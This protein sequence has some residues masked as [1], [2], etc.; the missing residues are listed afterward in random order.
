MTRFADELPVPVT[1]VERLVLRAILLDVAWRRGEAVH[2]SVHAHV[3]GYRPTECAF[4]PTSTL[5]RFWKSATEGPAMAFRGWI[6][7]FFSEFDRTHRA[8]A[9]TRAAKTIRRDYHQRWS[10]STLARRLHVTPSQLRRGFQQEFG[11][12][13]REY[14]RTIRLAEAIEHMPAG[15]IDAIA[16][17]VGYRSKK[18]FYHAF[19]Q[20]TGLTPTAFRR[21]PHERSAKVIESIGRMP[22]RKAIAADHGRRK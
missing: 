22:P 7:A 2:R 19:Q 8:S 12:S 3:H 11:M 20:V 21:L 1:A 4:N 17:Q 10:L 9:A 14:Q 18:N 6:E 16:L 13:V 15:K 5:E